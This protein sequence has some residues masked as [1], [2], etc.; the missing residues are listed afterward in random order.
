MTNRD[1]Y[2]IRKCYEDKDYTLIV[3]N[4]KIVVLRYDVNKVVYI[5]A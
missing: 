4:G 2:W 1:K 3:D 5:I